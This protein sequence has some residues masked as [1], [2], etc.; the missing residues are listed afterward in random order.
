MG[1]YIHRSNGN[2]IMF[3]TAET[4]IK[5]LG[6]R[7][8][9]HPVESGSQI[10]DHIITDPVSVDIEGFFSDA[11]FRLDGQ[12]SFDLGPGRAQ[13]ILA[14]L[15][16]IRDNREIF[17]LE[18]RDTIYDNMVLTSFRVPR[19]AE[20]GD[21]SR[22]QITCRQINRVE[23][24]FVLV[25]RAEAGSQDAAA[26]ELQTGRQATT[27]RDQSALFQYLQSVVKVTN[28]VGTP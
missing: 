9:D 23:R 2:T 4:V 15:E 27:P 13:A 6:S 10:T 11:A 5:D 12:D 26:D 25:P 1:T 24:R 17:Q 19:D 7:T 18:T 14:E 28:E 16:S 20:T 8:T 3:D 22:V 21:A